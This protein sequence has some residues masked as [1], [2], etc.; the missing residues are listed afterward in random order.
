M[1]RSIFSAAQPSGAR[2]DLRPLKRVLWE[3]VDRADVRRLQ[4]YQ[5][6]DRYIIDDHK[7]ILGHMAAEAL[8]TMA[9]YRR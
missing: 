6:S 7:V 4:H 8:D 2:T 3:L 5:D 9:V 1:G